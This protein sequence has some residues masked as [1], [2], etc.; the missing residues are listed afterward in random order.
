MTPEHW[1][2]RHCPFCNEP[3]EGLATFC[4]NCER[5][6][7]E[8]APP[9]PAASIPDTR[10]EDQ[11]KRDAL[12]AVRTLGWSVYDLEQGFRPFTCRHC[13]GSIAG[14]TRVPLGTPDW[15]VMGHGIAAWI[16]WKSGAGRQTP[17]QRRFQEACRMAGIAYRVC[18]TTEEALAFLKGLR[19]PE[20]AAA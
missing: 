16:E 13:G 7:D 18:R 1:R 20:G 14:G 11:R 19:T 8:A 10:S 4:W 3:L 9:V 15:Y 17:E 5:Y 12:E 2:Q 6:A